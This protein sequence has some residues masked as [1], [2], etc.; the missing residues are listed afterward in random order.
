MCRLRLG[1]DPGSFTPTELEDIFTVW[2]R[3]CCNVSPASAGSEL[4]SA[5]CRS[6]CLSPEVHM[7]LSEQMCRLTSGGLVQTQRSEGEG[8][9]LILIA[10]MWA[11]SHGLMEIVL[12]ARSRLWLSAAAGPEWR[13]YFIISSS[14]GRP[15][16]ITPARDR[17]HLNA[18]ALVRVIDTIQRAE[19]R[20][21]ESLC[22]GFLTGLWKIR[23]IISTLWDRKSHFLQEMLD[24]DEET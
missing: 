18:A 11:E 24:E 1:L 6:A 22:A 23:E 4:P 10:W 7:F 21:T 14:A 13:T 16:L 15:R 19:A 20:T 2:L 5:S 3:R 8:V 12:L 9:S 17:I